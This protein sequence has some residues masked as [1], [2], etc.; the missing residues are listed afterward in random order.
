[1]NDRSALSLQ[2]GT[3]GG[4]GTR[5]HPRALHGRGRLP[6]AAGAGLR[7]MASTPRRLLVEVG[8]CDRPYGLP[9]AD[10]SSAAALLGVPVDHGGH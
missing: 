9:D 10:A 6:A 1:M 4:A 2:R 7:V 8:G 5:R 3:A